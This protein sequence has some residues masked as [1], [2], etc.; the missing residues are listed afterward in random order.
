MLLVITGQENIPQTEAAARFL[1]ALV[2]HRRHHVNTLVG[3]RGVPTKLAGAG[4][5]VVLELLRGT[6]DVVVSHQDPVRSAEDD[7]P[8]VVGEQPAAVLGGKDI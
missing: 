4:D 8:L 1:V 2:P 5:G 3:P 6:R 7:A